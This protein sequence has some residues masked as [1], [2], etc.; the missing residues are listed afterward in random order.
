MSCTSCSTPDQAMTVSIDPAAV[1]ADLA[2]AI[3]AIRSLAT[4]SDFREN[5]PI[6]SARDVAAKVSALEDAF[7]PHS[8][9]LRVQLAALAGDLNAAEKAK[10]P[11]SPAAMM[12]MAASHRTGGAPDPLPALFHETPDTGPLNT[13]SWPA[14]LIF[15]EARRR[16]FSYWF[17]ALENFRKNSARRAAALN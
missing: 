10:T 3:A 14:L 6:L 9:A 2:P 13:D 17:G 12:K 16:Y 8:Q 15:A 11:F 4:F 7:R 5:S 1:F